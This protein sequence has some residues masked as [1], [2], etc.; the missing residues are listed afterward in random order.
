VSSR[1]V[2]QL[3]PDRLVALITGASTDKEMFA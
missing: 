2:G 1:P 3:S